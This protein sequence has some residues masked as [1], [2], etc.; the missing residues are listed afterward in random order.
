VTAVA[1]GRSPAADTPHI[2]LIFDSL[3]K[4]IGITDAILSGYGQIVLKV[5]VA[6]C[7]GA[8]SLVNDVD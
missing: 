3:A 5:A 4:W 7:L 8:T 6:D 2:I 1:P